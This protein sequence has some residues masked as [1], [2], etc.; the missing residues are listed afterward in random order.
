M[1][2]TEWYSVIIYISPRDVM[3]AFYDVRVDYYSKRKQ[4]LLNTLTDAWEKLDNKVK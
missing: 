2:L 4:H 1:Y 3:I